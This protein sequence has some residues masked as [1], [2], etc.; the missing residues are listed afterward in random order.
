VIISK[1]ATTPI[2]KFL[3]SAIK[4]TSENPVSLRINSNNGSIIGKPN[5]DNKTTFPVREVIVENN[6]NKLLNPTPPKNKVKRTRVNFPFLF[7]RKGS[8]LKK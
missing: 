8:F 2:F 6:V 3:S 5:T 4:S 7:Q 1:T